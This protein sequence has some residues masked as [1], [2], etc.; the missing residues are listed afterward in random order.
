MTIAFVKTNKAISVKYEHTPLHKTVA[1]LAELYAPPPPPPRR[2]ADDGENV[3]GEGRKKKRKKSQAAD[4]AE[5]GEGSTRKRRKKKA[6]DLDPDA[7]ADEDGTPVKT[8]KPRKSR[9]SKGG[10][11]KSSGVEGEPNGPNSQDAQAAT[12][13]NALLNLP[14]G[15]A[16]RRRDEANRKLSEAGIEPETL[17]AEQFSIFSNQSPDLQAESLSMLVKYGA[18]R[19]RIVHPNK[20]AN[21]S[22]SANPVTANANGAA[23]GTPGKGAKR[24]RKKA[25]EE[26]L[27]SPLSPKVPKP[28][29]T[30]GACQ[31]CRAKKMKVRCC[32]KTLI[33]SELTNLVLKK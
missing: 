31:A 10:R 6:D 29:K 7:P 13:P 23:E 22:P 25:G 12:Q 1:E 4:G 20:D 26:R 3:N 17:S 28:K 27:S 14:P 33:A 11:K 2:Q 32:H 24:S 15:E 19:L 8:P 21:S 30:R 18:E 5:N 9:A 16:A